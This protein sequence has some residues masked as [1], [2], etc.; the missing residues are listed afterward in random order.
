[1]QLVETLKKNDLKVY[2]LE[3]FLGLL[4][5]FFPTGSWLVS[6]G[7]SSV[8]NIIGAL[9]IVFLFKKRQWIFDRQ[10]TFVVLSY[11]LFF[12]FTLLSW[13][14]NGQGPENTNLLQAHL[15]FL[16]TIPGLYGIMWQRPSEGFFWWGVV[17]GAV[18]IGSFTAYMFFQGI[19]SRHGINQITLINPIE[20]GQF[21]VILASLSVVSIPYFCRISP[22]LSIIPASGTILGL[23]AALGS[24]TRGAWIAIPI[25][26]MLIVWHFRKSLLNHI[27]KTITGCF[28]CILVLV[29]FSGNGIIYQR[30]DQAVQNSAAYFDSPSQRETS[31]GSRLDL[32][33]AA[34]EC[35]KSSLFFGPGKDFFQKTLK[36]GVQEDIY[37]K[38]AGKYHFPHNEYASAFAY[39]GII[40]LVSLLFFLSVP[41]A[42][43]LKRSSSDFKNKEVAFTGLIVVICFVIFGLTDSPFE[44]R[45]TI[46]FYSIMQVVPLSLSSN[47]KK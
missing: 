6:S 2:W 40:G 13:L 3:L 27:G 17:L 47:R 5:F 46:I 39:H 42:V 44:Q 20:F 45:D 1:L 10:E 11:L 8:F 30:L 25:V 21:S 9:G 28:T 29:F 34:L 33:K 14:F 15:L 16:L 7:G 26:F 19:D 18:L 36:H 41:M 12:L 38:E 23:L 32:W 35:G 22:W 37:C 24:Q 4:I 43:F 31:V